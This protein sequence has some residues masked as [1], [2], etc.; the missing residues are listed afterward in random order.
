MLCAG[1]TFPT[2][3]GK[4]HFTPV[5]LPETARQ[6]GMF[7]LSTRRGK[8]FNSMVQERVDALTGAGREAVLM[9]PADAAKLGVG[10]GDPVL[11]KSHAGQM[12]ARVIVAPVTP[13]N[14]QVHWPEGEV[15]IDRS[16][17][18]PVAGIP[19]YNAQ[20]TVERSIP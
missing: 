15:L 9:N 5:A 2:P 20:V 19:D 1:W 18:S 12:R 16:T 10:D 8:Q 17:R 11:L 3:D 7:A 14:L 13:G 6:D 4:A